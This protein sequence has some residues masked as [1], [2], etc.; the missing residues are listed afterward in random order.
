MEMLMVTRPL[1]RPT[2]ATDRVLFELTLDAIFV[3]GRDGVIVDLNPAAVSLLGL[4][5]G[6]SIAT[7]YR[8]W[9]P[10]DWV[11][12]AQGVEQMLC[13]QGHWAGEFPIRRAD[14]TS[15]WAEG[16][17]QLDGERVLVVAR[18]VTDRKQAATATAQLMGQINQERAR[19]MGLIANV[20]G[21]VWE[22][23]GRPDQQTQRIDFVSDY[24][25]TLLGYSVEEWLA[26]P[27]FWLTIVHPDD[28]VQAAAKA[29]ADFVNGGG[30]NQ[31]RWVTKTGR[32]LDCEAVATVIKDDQ[33][34]PIGMRG[35]TFDRTALKRAERNR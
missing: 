9:L 19:L 12:P 25:E 5:Q 33:G 15:A 24:V 21:V 2:T 10:S 26:T 1:P 7:H 29:H 18:D 11:E 23:W 3:L 17:A 34:Q 31:F 27:N 22:A 35:I 6:Q 16:R 20:P 14:G 32:T 8:T 4:P 30:V 28:Q 13:H